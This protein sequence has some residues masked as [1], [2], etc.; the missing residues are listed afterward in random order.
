MKKMKMSAGIHVISIHKDRKGCQVVVINNHKSQTF[1]LRVRN[2]VFYRFDHYH[3]DIKRGDDGRPIYIKTP[4]F[5]PFSGGLDPK[6]LEEK[7]A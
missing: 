1:H 6:Y 4:V 2:G 7:A 5:T 3:V